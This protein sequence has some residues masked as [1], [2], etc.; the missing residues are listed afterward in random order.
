MST[1][2]PL[3]DNWFN[4][5]KECSSEKEAREYLAYKLRW[6]ADK[7]ESNTWPRVFGFE[8]KDNGPFLEITV[9][10]SHPWGG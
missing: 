6:F 3:Q 8:S 4:L 7:I 10:L 1:G 5:I 2:F 9:V